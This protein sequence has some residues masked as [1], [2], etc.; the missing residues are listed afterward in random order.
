MKEHSYK[1][2]RSRADVLLTDLPDLIPLI[3][4]NI[5]DNEDIFKHSSSGTILAKAYS[6]GEFDAQSDYFLGLKLCQIDFL[7][8]SD[9]IYYEEVFTL[10]IVIINL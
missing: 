5:N 6:W 1:I 10:M 9:L 4:T 2:V 8:L 7:I 3:Q